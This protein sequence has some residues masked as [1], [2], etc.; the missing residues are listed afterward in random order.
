MFDTSVVAQLLYHNQVPRMHN[1]TWHYAGYFIYSVSMQELMHYECE[2]LS[3]VKCVTCTR[4]S[5]SGFFPIVA[6][7]YSIYFV[8]HAV[9]H[10]VSV[11]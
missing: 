11:Y 7:K 8:I 4:F 2:C 5:H 1:K 9:I 3:S 10:C 6:S